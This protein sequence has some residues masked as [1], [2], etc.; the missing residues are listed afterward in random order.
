MSK[1]NWKVI[2]KVLPGGYTNYQFA[3]GISRTSDFGMLLG[4]GRLGAITIS[5]GDE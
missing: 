3:K 1:N 4:Y 2:N 5:R